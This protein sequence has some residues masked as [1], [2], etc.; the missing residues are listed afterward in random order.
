MTPKEKAVELVNGFFDKMFD[1][2]NS[3]N[4]EEVF[5]IAK[6]C[7]LIAIDLPLEEYEDDLD[8]RKAYKRCGYLLE[9]KEEIKDLNV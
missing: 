8:S 7:A 6:E 9:V 5:N 1:L 3:H 4:Y 2:R